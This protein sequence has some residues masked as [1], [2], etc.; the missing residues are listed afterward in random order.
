MI[1]LYNNKI[2]SLKSRSKNTV[3]IF[4]QTINSLKE[5]NLKAKEEK[6]IRTTKMAD[7]QKEI[8]DIEQIEQSNEKVINKINKIFD[9]KE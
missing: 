1:T 5:I 4:T 6:D 2:E 7:I 3:D 9:D 8:W